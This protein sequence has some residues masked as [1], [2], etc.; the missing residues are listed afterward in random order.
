M[1][2]TMSSQRVFMQWKRKRTYTL[3]D[4]QCTNIYVEKEPVY[5]MGI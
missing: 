3:L 4:E 2:P 1:T 5:L